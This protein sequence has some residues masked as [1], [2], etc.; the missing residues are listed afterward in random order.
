MPLSPQQAA[1]F[2]HPAGSRNPAVIERRAEMLAFEEMVDAVDERDPAAAILL[3]T[4]VEMQVTA[5]TRL[6]DAVG[7]VLADVAKTSPETADNLARS[8]VQSVADNRAS[9]RA[10][11][12]LGTHEGATATIIPFPSV[13][14]SAS[15]LGADSNPIDL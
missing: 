11:A 1:Q 5:G 12:G 15:T 13:H 9:L 10:S 7:S 2:R 14:P 3:R 6:R 8:F 4:A